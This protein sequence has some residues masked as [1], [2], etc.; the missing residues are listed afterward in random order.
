MGAKP[1]TPKNPSRGIS[2]KNI[3]GADLKGQDV[4]YKTG[5]PYDTKKTGSAAVSPENLCNITR[6]RKASSQP[7]SSMAGGTSAQKR[8]KTT[9]TKWLPYTQ[10][11]TTTVVGGK[12]LPTWGLIHQGVDSTENWRVPIY[13]PP[14]FT[15]MQQEA[16][17]E[18]KKKKL[19]YRRYKPGQ[20]ALKEIKYCK[21]RPGFIIPLA[22]IRRLCLEVGYNYKQGISFQLHAYRILQE[23]AEWYLV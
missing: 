6:K 14:K 9:P 20:L 5:V 1:Q 21:K 16:K 18:A 7:K 2:P 8:K 19:K 22:A 13:K 3:R 4:W 11:R 12:V 17:E 23:A 15:P 10:P